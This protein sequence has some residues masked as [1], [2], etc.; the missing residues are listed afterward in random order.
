MADARPDEAQAGE[1]LR[2][3]AELRT[4]LVRAKAR[5][6]FY[7]A[8]YLVIGLL[9]VLFG[10]VGPDPVSLVVGAAGAAI[11]WDERREARRLLRGEAGA[12]R[13]L[14]RDELVLL[15]VLAVYCVLC[16]TLLRA[17]GAELQRAAGGSLPG[18]DLADLTDRLTNI[19]Y[20]TLLAISLIVQGLLA[21][22]YAR[23]EPVAARY[24]EE[25]PE[26]AREALES[27]T[28]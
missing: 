20:P 5:A 14:A 27:A 26:W 19:V 4:P 1:L 16:L 17:D 3:A 22:F 15:G 21:R 23:Q 24:R 7:A 25:A 28:G 13:A 12:A 18:I 6:D 10:L 2:R 9:A 8:G 11:G